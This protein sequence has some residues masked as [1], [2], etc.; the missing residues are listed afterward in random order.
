MRIDFNEVKNSFKLNNRIEAFEY[1]EYLDNFFAIDFSEGMNRI[2]EIIKYSNSEMDNK[3][4]KIIQ[5]ELSKNNKNIQINKSDILPDDFNYLG[6][7]KLN[8][9]LEINFIVKSLLRDLRI[10]YDYIFQLINASGI[11]G[12][13]IDSYD[14]G[15]IPKVLNELKKD[16]KYSGLIDK[17]DYY[18]NTQSLTEQVGLFN[19]ID[20]LKA[21]DNTLKHVGNKNIVAEY[22]YTLSTKRYTIKYY[23]ERFQSKD[24]DG[25]IT[26]YPSYEA[27][28]ILEE[29]HK[30]I[31]MLYKNVLIEIYK[32]N[33]EKGV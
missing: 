11:I 3:T 7:I 22:W 29:I 13:S 21:F 27:I 17:L 32:I 10:S 31:E 1:C 26:K 24:N 28:Q 9:N 33:N 2:N 16:A 25:R 20:Y 12:A 6:E 19:S 8:T 5:N 23:I 14:R 15:V 18:K 30:H 4:S